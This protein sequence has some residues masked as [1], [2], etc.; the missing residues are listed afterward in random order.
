MNILVV[1]KVEE[2]HKAVLQAAAPDA[3]IQYIDAAKVD[4]DTVQQADIIVGNLNPNLIKDSKNL[5]LLQLN[6]AGTDGYTAPGVIPEQ[7]MLCNATGSYGLAISEHMVGMVLCLMK[8]FH[9]YLDEQ[10]EENWSNHGSVTSIYGAKTLVVGLGDIGNEFAVRMHAMGSTITGIRRNKAEKPE[11]IENLYQMD[12][13]YE[14]LEDADIV[15]TCLPG[16]A[17]TYKLFDEKAFSHMKDGA[18]F[19]NVGRGNAVDQDAL[20]EALCSGKLAGA[21]IDVT[22]PEP[23]PAGDKLWSAPNLM[24]TPHVSGGYHLRETHN[25]IIRIAARNIQHCI[26]GEPYE[27]EVD[28]STGYRKFTVNGETPTHVL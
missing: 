16:T 3:N 1:M 10:K 19:I 12:H 21:G 26:K 7:A 23:L 22:D 14:C 9:L 13:F 4:K 17:A 11:Y 8:K 2:E 25:R 27:N 20:Y 15:A 24:I 18:Y 28:M 5:K 6:S